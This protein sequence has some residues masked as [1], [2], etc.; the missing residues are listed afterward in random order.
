MMYDDNC[1]LHTAAALYNY[2]NRSR[3]SADQVSTMTGYLNGP[4]HSPQ[5]VAEMLEIL[6]ISDGTYSRFESLRQ[7]EAFISLFQIGTMF[8]FGYSPTSGG[9]G[10]IMIALRGLTCVEY[11]DYQRYERGTGQAG[12]AVRSSSFPQ[13]SR[14]FVYRPGFVAANGSP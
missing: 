6:G 4:A 9:V 12:I 7:A 11:R 8:G 14:F 1:S 5:S 2:K 3:I 13:S 10:H